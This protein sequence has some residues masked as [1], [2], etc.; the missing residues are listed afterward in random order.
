MSVASSAI[1]AGMR[2][3]HPA[4]EDH[5]DAVADELHLLE[6]GGV[7]EHRLALGGELAQQAV[8]LLL[9]AHV[10]A[11]GRVEAEDGA[12]VGGDPAGDGHL[13]LVAA[14][15]AL[16]LGL[17]AGV[18]LQPLDGA[19]D[20]RRLAAAVDR[21]PAAEPGAERQGDV[22][23]DRALHQQALAAVAGNEGDAGA[24]RVGGVGELPSGAVD[25][26]AAARGTDRAGE[27]GEELVLALA[28]ERDDA[29]DLAVAEVEGDVVELGA[30]REVPR[31]KARRAVGLDGAGAAGGGA[32]TVDAGAEHQ[33][34]DALLDAGGDV[35]DADGLA[36]AQHGGAV[37][38][39]RDL[40]EPVRDEDDGASGLALAADDVEHALGEV[41]G[42]RGGHLVEEQDVG[43][44]RQG[45]GEVEDALHRERQVAG[46]VAQVEVGDAELADPVEE[47]RGRG[48]GQAQVVGDVE[49]GDQRRLLV[50][51]DEAG[52]AGAGGRAEVAG[53]A[54]DKDASGVGPDRAGQDLHERRLAG[55]VGAH[56]GVHL[57]GE[58]RERGVAERRDR[59]VALGDAGGVEDRGGGHRTGRAIGRNTRDTRAIPDMLLI[60]LQFIF[61]RIRP[62]SRAAGC[63]RRLAQVQ[64]SPGPL[65]ATICSLV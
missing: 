56:Q 5:H 24:D 42:Q 1:S 44:D 47:R 41:R 31:R 11:A 50:D 65:Q 64:L 28:L 29:D 60:L 46:E 3:D 34:D 4:A 13:L 45:A 26:D 18:D 54:A 15:E 57:A 36:V 52:A 58:D 51:R 38:E 43:V 30:D 12:G 6:L 62:R 20:G 16:H 59:A 19:A 33:L 14:G 21:P 55:A 37:A 23:A 25:L 48:A 35:E 39:H 7:E 49:V 2:I 53:L 27:R 32:G 63:C 8:D 22:L 17:G 10:D 40:E 61:V 9:G